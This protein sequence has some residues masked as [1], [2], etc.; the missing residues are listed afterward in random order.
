MFTERLTATMAI[1]VAAG[2]F[3]CTGCFAT[4]GPT[5]GVFSIPIPVSPYFQKKLRGR[6][7]CARALRAVPDLGT[8]DFRW[9]SCCPGSSQLMMKFGGHWNEQTRVQGGWP[10]PLRDRNVIT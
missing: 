6:A 5:L 7:L 8:F 9:P 3:Q 10:V 1:L 2:Q 4:T